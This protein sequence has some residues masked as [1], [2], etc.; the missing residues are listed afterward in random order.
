MKSSI[1]SAS[2]SNKEKHPSTMKLQGH[3]VTTT[4]SVA[5][6]SKYTT[7]TLMVVGLRRIGKRILGKNEAENLRAKA[8]PVSSERGMPGRGH[9]RSRGSYTFKSL[10]CMYH[11]SDTNHHTQDCPIFLESKRKMEQDT[12][13][14]PQHSLSR[15]VNHTTHWPSSHNHYSPSYPSLFT[16]QTDQNNQ[17]QATITNPITTPQPTILSF[18][19]LHK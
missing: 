4:I 14:P 15:E 13:Q 7:W 16:P 17:A 2:S 19:Q 1:N 11:D 18:R 12:N 3:L 5:T 6:P 10:Y 8:K 9:G